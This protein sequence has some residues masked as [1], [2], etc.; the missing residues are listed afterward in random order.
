MVNDDDRELVAVAAFESRSLMRDAS[1]DTRACGSTP[2]RI[3]SV[4]SLMVST[5]SPD[6]AALSKSLS[7]LQGIRRTYRR[8]FKQ[9][10]VLK[11]WLTDFCLE[12]KMIEKRKAVIDD[13]PFLEPWKW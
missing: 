7:L 8:R 6:T 2:V 10:N 3:S 4:V 13:A 11:S 12:M 9:K 5:V 1:W